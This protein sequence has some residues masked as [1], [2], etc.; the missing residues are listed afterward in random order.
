MVVEVSVY[1]FPSLIRSL[2]SFPFSTGK[3]IFVPFHVLFSGKKKRPERIM[4]KI[5]I[6]GYNMP[7]RKTHSI[8]K[9]AQ[10]KLKLS[11]LKECHEQVQVAMHL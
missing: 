8:S 6:H 2:L 7:L 5:L 10:G 4:K 1:L 9:R 11:G 3:L